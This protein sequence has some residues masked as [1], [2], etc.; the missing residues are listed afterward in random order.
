MASIYS[1][2]NN[3]TA[4]EAD[5][6]NNDGD[7]NPTN[8]V[9][10]FGDAY[11]RITDAQYVSNASDGCI[12]G[13]FSPL[14]GAKRHGVAGHADGDLR[15]P[16]RESVLCDILDFEGG[17]AGVLPTGSREPCPRRA[18]SRTRSWR[19]DRTTKIIRTRSPSTN[20]STSSAS[21]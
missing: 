16:H 11:L 13:P 4:R 12:G 6:S 1:G 9:G 15:E 10:Q 2:L 14:S 3:L 7:N 5:G 17:G 8:D 21:S 18:P 20:C 19:W